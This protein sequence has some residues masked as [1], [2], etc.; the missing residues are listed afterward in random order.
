M[1]EDGRHGTDAVPGRS[2]DEEIAA[3]LAECERDTEEAD[4]RVAEGRPSTARKVVGWGVA[5][6]LAIALVRLLLRLS[7]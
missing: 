4:R 1:R 5:I 7:E 3:V 2:K 6:A